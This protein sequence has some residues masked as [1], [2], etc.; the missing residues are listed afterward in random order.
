MEQEVIGSTSS[1]LGLLV[2][3]W[4]YYWSL[5]FIGDSMRKFSQSSIGKGVTFT[6]LCRVRDKRGKIDYERQ[7]I[8]GIITENDGYVCTVRAWDGKIHSNIETS[9]IKAWSEADRNIEDELS[10]LV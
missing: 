6:K 1:R 9:E 5:L 10:C 8:D 7:E 4:Y 2:H 3:P